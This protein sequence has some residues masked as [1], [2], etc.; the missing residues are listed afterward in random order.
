M[1]YCAA[2]ATSV[3]LTTHLWENFLLL[4]KESTSN[5]QQPHNSLDTNMGNGPKKYTRSFLTESTRA[6]EYYVV[7]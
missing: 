4:Y 6:E 5:S 7:T 2:F 3:T 1:D